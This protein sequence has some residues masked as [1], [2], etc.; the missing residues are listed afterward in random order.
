MRAAP[1]ISQV[2]ILTSTSQF[3]M[4]V[5]VVVG[6]RLDERDTRV[7]EQDF[8]DRRKSAEQFQQ[9]FRGFQIVLCFK[10]SNRI[11]TAIFS[12]WTNIHL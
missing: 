12:Q 5:V 4:H 3:D 8:S 9:L 11:L 1:E 7:I 6:K 2:V 10:P